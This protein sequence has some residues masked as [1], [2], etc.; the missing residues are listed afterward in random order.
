MTEHNTKQRLN[1]WSLLFFPLTILYEEV[2]LRIGAVDVTGV[3]YHYLYLVIFAAAFGM[4]F[5]AITQLF[6]SRTI[7]I[8]LTALITF[9]LVVVFCAEYCAKSFFQ[10]FFEISYMLSMAGD[11]T[12]DF[13]NETIETIFTS[14]PYILAALYPMFMLLALNKKIVPEEPASR[15][16]KA[17]AAAVFAVLEIATVLVLM[18]GSGNLRDDRDYFTADYSVN[19][20]ITRFGLMCSMQL[21]TVYGIFGI[22]ETTPTLSDDNEVVIAEPTPTPDPVYGYN[23]LDI[24]FEALAAS[25]TDKTVLDMHQYFASMTPTQKNEYTGMFEGK[26]L[27]FFVAEAFSP[28]VIDPELTPTLYKLSTEG[29]VFNNYY[30]PDWHQS[31]TGGEFASVSG[32]VPTSVDGNLSFIASAKK[33]MPFALGHQ[34]SNLG[35]ACRAYHNNTFN[36]YERHRTHPNLGYDYKGI[37]SGLELLTK[38]SWPHSDHEMIQVTADEYINNYVNNGER[39]HTYYMT[40]S[41]HAGYYWDTNRQAAKHKEEVD[42]LDY[43]TSV[44]GYLAAQLEVE[45]AVTE[46]LDKLEAA[47]IADDT[48]I[49]LTS[50]HYPYA[51]SDKAYNELEPVDTENRTMA[52]YKNTLLLWCGSMEEPVIIDDPC[53]S[54]DIIPT[55]SNLFGLEYDSRLFSGR[56]ILSTNYD[57]SNPNSPQPFVIGA[58]AGIGS[59]WVSLAGTYNASTKEFIPSP[60]YEEYA[61]NQDY[62]DAMCKKAKNMFKYSKNILAKDYYKIVTDALEAAKAT[63]TPEPTPE[64]TPTPEPSPIADAVAET[65]P[66]P[67]PSAIPET[68]PEVTPAA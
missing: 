24:D 31:T 37:Y 50:D 3:D 29:F 30:Q 4:L 18:L 51:L 25:T 10:I 55:L 68:A 65:T 11:V 1:L 7:R 38:G 28:Y 13:A 12:N 48:V 35:Y 67:M 53:S 15:K 14:I 16:G 59:S 47:G 49:V 21:E 19:S 42:H 66:S 20:A 39:F 57:V 63:P 8:I 58:D 60:G 33:A 6:R 54:I 9:L 2:L 40:V 61:E 46:L 62:I 64:A 26:N 17:L 32:L 41:G 36:F 23:T 43:S 5:W 45:Y 52:R 44:K 22:P 56:D 34:F 27:V